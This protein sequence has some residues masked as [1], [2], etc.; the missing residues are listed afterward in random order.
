M[1]DKTKET[2]EFTKTRSDEKISEA[3]TS[4]IDAYKDAEVNFE[5]DFR[6]APFY[7]ISTVDAEGNVAR[8]RLRREG[9]GVMLSNVKWAGLQS[10]AMTVADLI[11]HIGRNLRAIQR[12]AKTV[13]AEA[14]EPVEA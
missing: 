8:M 3:L 10:G 2:K 12:A 5:V 4:A 9:R 1:T 7:A 14:S 6:T 13:E 11:N